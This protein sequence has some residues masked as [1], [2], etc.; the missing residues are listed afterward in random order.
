MYRF[1][2][3]HRCAKAD[4]RMSW[5]ATK[6][7]A[8]RAAEA[9]VPGVVFCTRRSADS[10]A[11]QVTRL[12]NMFLHG[13]RA[14]A[15]CQQTQDIQSIASHPRDRGSSPGGGLRGWHLSSF[16]RVTHGSCAARPCRLVRRRSSRRRPLPPPRSDIFRRHK[17]GPGELACS[18][19]RRHRRIRCGRAGA[20]A[21]SSLGRVQLRYSLAG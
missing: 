21:K 13:G 10:I 16:T 18:A 19:E 4:I 6:R 14:P 15:L 11:R 7:P 3:A 1:Q 12:Q 2:R 20:D 8:V 17:T 9:D 5:R